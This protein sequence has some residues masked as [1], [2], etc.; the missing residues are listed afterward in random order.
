M[1]ERMVRAVASPHVDILGH[2]TGTDDR[3]ARPVDVRRRLRVRRLRPVPHRGRDQLP[4]RAARS[5]AS[6]ARTWRSTTAATSPSTATPTPPASWSG[7][8]TAA[9]GPPSAR[10]R[11]SGSSTPG[12]STT[13]FAGCRRPDP[14]VALAPHVEEDQEEEGAHAPLEG[15]PR[16][17]TQHGTWLNQPFSLHLR[18]GVVPTSRCCTAFPFADPYRWLEDGESEEVAAWVAAHNERT[19]Q[20][21]EAR[22]TWSQWHER[23]SALTA[24]PTVASAAVRGDR[25]F[26]LGRAAGADQF[27][28]VVQSA[29]D[30]DVPAAHAARPVATAPPTARSRSTGA[31]LRPDGSLVA[32]G[33][34]EGGTEQSTLSVIDV[35][36]AGGIS[37][38]RS[39]TPGHRRSPGCPTTP[40][41]GTCATHPSN[42]YDRHVYFHRL[43]TD[44]AD[45]PVVFDDLPTPRDVARR[46]WP[47]TTV[48]TCWCTC[49]S[50]GGASTP[51]CSTR[52]QA[53]GAMSS[54]AIEAQSSFFFHAGELYGVT[55][56][57]ASN[58][59]VF[60]APLDNPSEWR[61]VVAERDVVLDQRGQS[62]RPDCWSCRARPLSTPSKSGTPTAP[63]HRAIDELGLI[64]VQSVD[65]D[66]DVAFVAVGSFDAPPTLY[67][68]TAGR[69][70]RW[71][72]QLDVSVLPPLT[73]TQ[74][75]YPSLDG[76]EIGLFVMHRVRRRAVAADSADAHRLRR[77]RDR[78]IAVVGG[79][80]R[81]VVRGG[82]CVRSRRSARRLRAR[83]GL[84]SCR[85][86]GQQA[87]RVRRLPRGRRLAG[88][89]RATRRA[90]CW[91]SR[92]DRTADC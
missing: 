23:L 72:A 10:C 54:A 68:V 73:V 9:T 19:H 66:G 30:R 49:W 12:A 13:C 41:S 43:G 58:G 89:S 90:T 61:T 17:A 26:V 20:A 35:A 1:T 51:D 86:P 64:S 31:S 25:L 34:S 29:V 59:R 47:A 62:R 78:R 55:S 42:Q 74:T 50:A 84:A 88:R 11:S 60:A 36:T 40:G 76:T 57:D 33:L 3:Q 39:P 70:E 75:T 77:V 48:A 53:S 63:C 44:P 14:P 67:R 87:E 5:A 82:W 92:A 80:R 8:R 71:S 2:C 4:P 83:R 37:T 52:R 81:G 27:S 91:P 21:L 65:T 7:S 79:A 56:R 15:Q 85:P 69:A 24:L 18:R 16:Q 22:P 32:I 46:A 6:A 28:L 45:D 38:T